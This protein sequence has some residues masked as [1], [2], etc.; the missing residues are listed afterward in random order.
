MIKWWKKRITFVKI[1][2]HLNE[3]IEWHCMQLEFSWIIIQ[4][5]SIQQLD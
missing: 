4:S 3:N 2:L 5:I 1:K